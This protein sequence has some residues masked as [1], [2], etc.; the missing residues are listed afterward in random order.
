MEQLM[1][2]RFDVVMLDIHLPR[3]SGLEVL[4][5]ARPAQPDACIIMRS[6]MDQDQLFAQAEAMGADATVTKPCSMTHVRSVICESQAPGQRI[7]SRRG[8]A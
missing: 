4:E 2:V 3:I 1:C 8:A 5:Q 6:G 7:S